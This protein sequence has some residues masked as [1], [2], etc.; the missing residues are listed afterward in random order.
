MDTTAL[1]ERAKGLKKTD[2]VSRI[3]EIRLMAMAALHGVEGNFQAWHYYAELKHLK[4]NPPSPVFLEAQIATSVVGQLR[5]VNTVR[6]LAALRNKR[7]AAGEE[8]LFESFI[9][10]L[11]NR[12]PTNHG[13]TGTIFGHRDHSPIWGAIEGHVE[14]L[15][16]LG[17]KCFLNSGTLLGVVR[18]GKLIDHDDDVDLAVILNATNEEDAAEEWQVLW[19]MLVDK[20]LQ[21]ARGLKSPGIYKLKEEDGCEI[22]LFPCWI[23]SGKA[24]IYPHTYADLDEAD[25]LP[26]A[27]C[28]VSGRPVPANPEKMLSVNYGE[29]WR[30]PDPYFKFPWANATRRFR[31]FL[32]AVS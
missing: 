4:R 14:A 3:E 6:A 28:D 21:G 25:V 8:E 23:D 27:T 26:L 13:Y 5:P 1:I 18:D 22:D 32:G 31:T 11:G 20:G 24:Y 10:L 16:R 7:V 17:Y 9:E 15:D 30:E 19:R 29:G 12:V 2:R